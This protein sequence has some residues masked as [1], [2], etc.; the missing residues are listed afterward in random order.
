MTLTSRSFQ[1]D[2]YK[3]YIQKLTRDNMRAH[4]VKNFGGWSDKVSKDKLLKVVETGVVQLFFDEDKFIGYVSFNPEKDNK[5]SLL[6]NDIHVVK[7]FQRKDYGF[8]ILNYVIKYAKTAFME[9]LKVFAFKDNYAV[10]FYEKN[11]FKVVEELE[12]SNSVI[13]TRLL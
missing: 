13:M 7:L 6:I 11:D 1:E 5:Y 4:F 3:E 10:N 2:D 12:K 9:Q 8:Q